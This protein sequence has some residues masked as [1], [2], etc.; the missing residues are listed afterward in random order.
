MLSS[1][2]FRKVNFR[3]K[4]MGPIE[5]LDYLSQT[6]KQFLSLIMLQ[7]KQYLRKNFIRSQSDLSQGTC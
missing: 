4:Y 6:L 3:I 2:Q 7:M 1:D 5:P